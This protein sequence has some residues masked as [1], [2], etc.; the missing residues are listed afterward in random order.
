[1]Y[2]EYWGLKESPF[3]NVP[4]P[5][6]MCHFSQHDE[7][8]MRMMFAVKGRKGAAMLTGDVGCGKTMLSRAFIQQLAGGPYEVGIIANPSFPPIDFLKEIIYQLGIRKTAEHKSDL[9]RILNEFMLENMKKGRD[10]IIIVDESQVIN[11]ADTYEELRL[12][13]NFQL[14]DRFLLTL[15]LI[16]QPELRDHIAAI[17]QFDQRIAIKYHI[18]PLNLS[19]T[20]KYI[21]FRLKTAGMQKN[22]FTKEAIMKIYEYTQGVPRRINNMCDLSLLVGFSQK[23]AVVDS[24]LI[25]KIIE[26][27][28]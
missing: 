17:P 14:N 13:L 6:F 26:D 27:R 24:K 22:V 4:D 11:N 15:I 2:N 9:L 25:Q 28:G 10:T 7:A 1:M 12:L 19:D 21:M 23:A 3:E 16:G 18:G 20:A 5:R 8:L